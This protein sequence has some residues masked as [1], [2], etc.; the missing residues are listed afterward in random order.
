MGKCSIWAMGMSL[1]DMFVSIQMMHLVH[2]VAAHDMSHH[3]RHH[4]LDHG[5]QDHDQFVE[6]LEAFDCTQGGLVRWV[7]PGTRVYAIHRAYARNEC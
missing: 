4:R 6:P 7:L 3:G 5:D 1:R 2:G